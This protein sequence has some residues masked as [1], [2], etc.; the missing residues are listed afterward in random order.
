MASRSCHRE[1]ARAI[2]NPPTSPACPPSM[3][4]DRWRTTGGPR[5]GR[6]GAWVPSRGLRR[7]TTFG[8]AA[9]LR[10]LKPA[11]GEVIETATRP[12]RSS[13]PRAFI[14]NSIR[15][16]HR[17]DRTSY[18]EIRRGPVP[19][20]NPGPA[21]PV[22]SRMRATWQHRQRRSGGQGGRPGRR[23]NAAICHGEGLK[24]LGE[25]AEVAGLQ[26]LYV[27]RRFRYADTARAREG[28]R[29]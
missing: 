4:S 20:G 14:V 19:H 16:R 8:Q 29:R 17:A 23:C 12:R 15:R 11:S 5:E 1:L 18:P 3:W 9:M 27:A 2:R 21:M 10:R 22:S 7:T 26:P 28:R 24:G 13:P 6:R 25:D